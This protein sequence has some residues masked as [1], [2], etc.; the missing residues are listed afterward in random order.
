MGANC[1]GQDSSPLSCASSLLLRG[2]Q[3]LC[4]DILGSRVRSEPRIPQTERSFWKPSEYGILGVGKAPGWLDCRETAACQAGSQQ[5]T[6]LRASVSL[7]VKEASWP[8]K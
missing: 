6:G 3:A 2:C 7:S 1:L 5:M 8:G 4:L